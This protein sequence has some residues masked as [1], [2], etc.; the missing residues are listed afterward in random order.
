MN[1]ITEVAI[2]FG[3]TRQNIWNKIKSGE[4][5]AVRFGK[6]WRITDEEF[7]RLKKG[8]KLTHNE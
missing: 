6:L 1:S 2:Y 7:E 8:L 4:I 3:T 5:K